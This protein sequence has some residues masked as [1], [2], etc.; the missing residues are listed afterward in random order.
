MS[1]PLKIYSTGG[2]TGLRE[3]SDADLDYVAHQIGA[4]LASETD[5]TGILTLN[6]N[7]ASG[8][9]IG[10]F[11]DTR[12]PNA[13]GTHPVGTSVTTVTYTFKQI[14][15][16]TSITPVRPLEWSSSAIRENADSELNSYIFTRVASRLSSATLGSYVLQP[17]APGTG[18]WTASATITNTYNSGSSSNTTKLWRCT[19]YTAPTAIRP[20][21]VFGTGMKEMSDADMQTLFGNYTSYV[22]STGIGKYAAQSA[23]PG[24]GT[25]VRMGSG[26]TDTRQIVSDVG[27]TGTYSANYTS[28]FAGSRNNTYSG[29]RGY[30]GSRNKSY[31][32]FYSGYARAY[33][34]GTYSATYVSAS[35][36]FTGNYTGNYTGYFAGSRNITYTGATVSASTENVSNVS[37]WLRTA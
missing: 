5:G 37:L 28:S 17:T 13:V 27:Y 33:Y 14:Q 23:A 10:T 11:T 6:V 15:T 8:T 31:G 7:G 18:T 19:S 30:A 21:K 26:F 16:T 35:Q 32:Q 1:R 29:T 24:T 25:W 22:S 12:R 36:N 4:R 9:N 2:L 34:T 20:V 3:M